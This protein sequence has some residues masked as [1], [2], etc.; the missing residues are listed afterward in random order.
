MAKIAS[1]GKIAE[2]EIVA[3]AKA[4]QKDEQ[5]DGAGHVAGL[6]VK[7][8]GVSARATYAS[9]LRNVQIKGLA[10]LDI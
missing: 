5:T 10:S 3:A 6:R 2:F 7:S 8:S 1:M 4:E 9:H